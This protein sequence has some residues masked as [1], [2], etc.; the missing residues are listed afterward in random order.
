MG[1]FSKTFTKGFVQQGANLNQIPNKSDAL[2]WLD[3]IITDESGTKYFRDKT[4]NGRKFLI[5]GYDFD[6]TWM[7]GMPYKSAATISAPVGDATLIA[8]DINS[9]LYTDGTPNQIPVVSLFQ[10]ID[11]EH[12]LFCRH[13]AQVVDGNGVE[14]NEARVFDIVLYNTVKVGGEL[15]NCQTYF[16]VPGEVISNVLWVAKTGNDSTGNGTKVNPYLTISKGNS[17]AL[18]KTIYVK[19]GEYTENSVTTFNLLLDKNNSSFISTGKATIKAGSTDVNVVYLYGTNIIS[20]KNFIV[21]GAKQYGIRSEG[22]TKTVDRCKVISATTASVTVQDGTSATNM[23]LIGGGIRY[24]G[25]NASVLN[26]L[27]KLSTGLGLIGSTTGTVN[28][29]NNKILVETGAGDITIYGGTLNMIGNK[30]TLNATG[31]KLFGQTNT[32][33]EN[34][35]FKYNSVK[36]SVN[37]SV[38]PIRIYCTNSVTTN[39]LNN[40]FEFTGSSITSLYMILVSTSGDTTIERNNFKSETANSFAFAFI[41]NTNTNSISTGVNYNYIDSK[42][43]TGYGIGIGSEVSNSFDN[44]ITASVFGNSLIGA[45]VYNITSTGSRHCVFVGHNINPVVKF[46]RINGGIIGIVIKHT[47]GVYTNKSVQYNL[48]TNCVNGILLKGLNGCSVIN[49]TISSV[50]SDGA[51]RGI[52]T[53]THTTECSNLTLNNN[54]IDL[55][56]ATNC[57]A[58]YINNGSEAG[59]VSDYN[60]LYAPSGSGL[61]ILGV[62]K[63][64]GQWQ[65]LGLDINSANS[66]ASL[67][68][69][70]PTI[71]IPGVDLGVD[72]DDGLDVSSTFGSSTTVPAIVI[73]QQGPTWQSGSYIQD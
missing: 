37:H 55:T 72:Y 45:R 59:L 71:P 56:I 35:V 48:I 61:N 34:I 23:C 47:G 38:V 14:T 68:T 15:I 67:V 13:F 41:Q 60:S 25:S 29:N 8:A 43:L 26:S 2:F 24:Y 73:K 49:N 36:S 50:L 18:N 52:I 54:I 64:F 65:A 9:Y 62:N 7:A 17:L 1:A 16:G 32:T 33:G 66:S 3:G 39:I 30:I 11:Y 22:A 40:N 57:F 70:I 4:D 5:T 10:D 63:T 12:K 53:E 27:V 6:S 21:D 46:N 42:S 20:F 51:I 69:E 31:V 19:T 44:K 28:Y 58:I